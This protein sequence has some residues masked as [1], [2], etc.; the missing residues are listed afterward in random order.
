MVDAGK[1]TA[2]RSLCSLP[3]RLIG[4]LK[5]HEDEMSVGCA[6]ALKEIKTKMGK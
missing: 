6:K 4:C 2:V 5:Q 1:L 3:G